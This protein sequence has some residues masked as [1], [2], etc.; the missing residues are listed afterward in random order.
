MI[1]KCVQFS[2]DKQTA[3]SNMYSS[4]PTDRP[5]TAMCIVQ[6]RQTDHRQQC[7]QFS[8]DRQTEDSNM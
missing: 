8:T 3:D 1:R 7:V 6:Y 5:Q 2:S 4:V